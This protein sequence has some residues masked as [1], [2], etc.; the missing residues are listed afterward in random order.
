MEPQ[1]DS[2]D[3]VITSLAT[4]FPLHHSVIISRVNYRVIDYWLGLALPASALVQT[5]QQHSE[6][7]GRVEED[8]V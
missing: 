1:I 8:K 6:G 5:G 7:S 4:V 3:D 2:H